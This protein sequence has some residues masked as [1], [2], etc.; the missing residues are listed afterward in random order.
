MTDKKDPIQQAK[1]EYLRALGES[2]E[3]KKQKLIE[4][5]REQAAEQEPSEAEQRLIEIQTKRAIIR[6]LREL[7]EAEERG[8]ELP[9]IS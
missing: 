6:R 7:K 8:E 4:E 9:Q 2:I 5:K 1:E 3:N